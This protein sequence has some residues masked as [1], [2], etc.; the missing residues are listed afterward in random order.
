[1]LQERAR[2][3]EKEHDVNYYEGLVLESPNSSYV[4]IHYIS[5]VYKQSGM[6]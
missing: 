5:F 1:M 2:P 4:W 3:E 6:E